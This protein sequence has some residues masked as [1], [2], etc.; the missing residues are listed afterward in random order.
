[1]TRVPSRPGLDG[2]LFK[3]WLEGLGLQVYINES[4]NVVPVL[5]E[6]G[7]VMVDMPLALVIPK[8]TGAPL[9]GRG[10]ILPANALGL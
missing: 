8:G 5:G 4:V 9:L 2:T 3:E 7:N 10:R 6:Y 1:M